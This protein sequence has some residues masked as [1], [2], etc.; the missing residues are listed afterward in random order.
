MRQA[1]ALY[2]QIVLNYPGTLAAEEAG[3]NLQTLRAAHPGLEQLPP[4]FNV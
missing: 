3:R 2:K 4:Q 1:I